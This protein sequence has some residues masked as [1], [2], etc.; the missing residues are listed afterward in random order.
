MIRIK[1]ELCIRCFGIMEEEIVSIYY[2]N[3]NDI[4]I[5]IIIWRVFS[6]VVFYYI[7]IL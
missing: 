7:F 2:N 5:I 4:M 6:R 1:L 3:N